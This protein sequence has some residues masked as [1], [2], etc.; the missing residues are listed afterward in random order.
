MLD[1]IFQG[2]ID[3]Y[4]FKKNNKIYYFYFSLFKFFVKSKLILPFKNYKFYSSFSKKDLSRW[5]LKNLAEWD[6]ESVEKISYFIKNFNV[7]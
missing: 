4:I 5:M 3:R 6:K 1:N 7:W 2:I